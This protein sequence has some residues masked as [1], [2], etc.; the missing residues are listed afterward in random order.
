MSWQSSRSR[1]LVTVGLGLALLAASAASAS[2]GK[3]IFGWVEHVLVGKTR[4]SM[5]AKLD[6]GAETSSLDA[7]QIKKLRRSGKRWVEFVVVDSD[8]GRRVN[9]KKPLLRE[10]RIKRHEGRSQL[11]PVV[12]MEIC[13]GDHL[14]RVQVSLIDRGEFLYPVLLG[15]R[16]LEGI[17]VVDPELSLTSTPGCPEEPWEE[18]AS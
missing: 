9:F 7:L 5:K 10:V 14:K 1:R 11:R 6:T 4:L 3:D 8:T 12:A 2:E 18:D 17:A 13:L 15:R 16:A